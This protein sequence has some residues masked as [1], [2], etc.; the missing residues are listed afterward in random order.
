[1]ET[2]IQVAIIGD[3][4]IGYILATLELHSPDQ[5]TPFSGAALLRPA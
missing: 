3:T 5:P 2:S 4:S 1:M